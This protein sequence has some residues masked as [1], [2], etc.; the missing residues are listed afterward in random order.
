MTILD[1][2][3]ELQVLVYDLDLKAPARAQAAQRWL[4]P[5][6]WWGRL[7]CQHDLVFVR[8][9]YGDQIIEWGYKR[10]VWRCSKCSKV[11]A[12][13]RETRND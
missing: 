6:E 8:N 11:I 4:S 1:D 7:R 13:D 3:E 5:S 2:T 9:L 12:Q 10:S